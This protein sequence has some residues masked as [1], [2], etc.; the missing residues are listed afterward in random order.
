MPAEWNYMP[1]LKWKQGEQIALRNLTKKQWE[2]ITP[3]IELQPIDAAPDLSSIKAALPNYLTKVASQ[4]VKTFP[5]GHS[6]CVDTCYLSSGYIWQVELLLHVCSV[7]QHNVA[8]RHIIPVIHASSVEALSN[9]SSKHKEFI[10]SQTD[11]LVRVITDNIEALQVL[12][13]VDE[14]LNLDLNKNEVHLLIDQFSLLGRQPIDC[15]SSV[16]EYVEYATNADCASVTIGG[17]SFPVNLMGRKQ[18]ITEIPRVEWGV[19]GLFQ[20]TGKYPDLRYADYAVTNPAPL[21][22][23]DA[24]KMNP[25][26]AIRYTSK[27]C[28]KLYKGRGF[29]SGVPGEYKALAKILVMDAVYS[30]EHFS[31]GDRQYKAAT[32][33]SDKN[34]NPSSWR[35]EATNHHIVF[36]AISL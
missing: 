1:I 28:W 36:T 8:N 24:T 4:I 29:K 34:G 21:P 20:K 14:I 2:G 23:I 15:F 12:P 5:E 30:G 7:L 9:I 11:I 6:V 19:W 31:Y 3:I 18:G 17:G 13:M 16:K 26:I 25:S 35:K 27:E 10:K 22:E 32:G 33:G